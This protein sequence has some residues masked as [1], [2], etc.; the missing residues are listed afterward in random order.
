MI[1]IFLDDLRDYPNDF[2][3][4]RNYR[5][6]IDLLNNNRVKIMTFDHDL[7]EEKTGYD[8][9]K[10]IVEM[11]IENSDFWPQLIYI[12]TSNPV[13]RNNIYQLLDRYKPEEV[14]IYNYGYK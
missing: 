7:G 12:H 8:V 14:E 13:G 10:Y 5:D 11:G 9:A 6:C 2:V 4:A 3:V 1:N